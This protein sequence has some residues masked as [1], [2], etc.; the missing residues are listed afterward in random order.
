MPL[1]N[2]YSDILAKRLIE[3]KEK[4]ELEFCNFIV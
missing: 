1:I 4:K 2:T 3:F